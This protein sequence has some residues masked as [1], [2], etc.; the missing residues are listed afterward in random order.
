MAT[1]IVLPV[2][3]EAIGEAV[4]VRW[5]KRAGEAVRRGEEIAELETNKATLGLE[6]P[7]DGVLLALMVEEGASV[8]IG[9]LLAVVGQEGEV[10]SGR[11]KAVEAE[12][13]DAALSAAVP[14]SPF[15]ETEQ[16]ISPAARKRA[17]ELGVDIRQV[18]PSAPGA[19]I[20]SED[21][22]R[23]AGV[24]MAEGAGTELPPFHIVELNEVRRITARRMSESVRTIPQFSVSV[25][26]DAGSLMRTLEEVRTKGG[27]SIPRVS[28][29]ALWVYLVGQ[30][31]PRHPLANARFDGERVLLFETV[32]LAVAVATPR[33]LVAPVIHAAERLT[34]SEAARQLEEAA[35]RAREGK[36]T[37]GDVSGATFT[38]SNLGMFGV[39]SFVPLVNPPQSAILGVGMV[40]TASLGL[41]EGETRPVQTVTL[42]LAADHRVMD[43]ADAARFLGDL[44]SAIEGCSLEQIRL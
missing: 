33:G 13:A 21:V 28:L 36:L 9:E 10:Y 29:T 43:G 27:E 31:L 12:E 2:L 37:P 5:Y 6:C 15:E 40:R 18:T 35:G 34:L 3:G 22:E 25:E 20:T 14:A 1:E 19:R 38:L 42:T 32:N 4:L 11:E 41:L 30:V 44:K 7:E 17:G 26:S 16:R 39:G 23:Y 24:K 8:H